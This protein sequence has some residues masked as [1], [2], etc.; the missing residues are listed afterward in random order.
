MEDTKLDLQKIL[1]RLEIIKSLVTLEEDDEIEL[2]ISKYILII[3]ERRGKIQRR[4]SR[5][6]GQQMV[7]KLDWF[8]KNIQT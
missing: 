3:P 4:I 1:K 7:K 8:S 2:H 5:Y 6:C